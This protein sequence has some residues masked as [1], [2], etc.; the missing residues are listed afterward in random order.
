MCHSQGNVLH[1]LANWQ[2]LFFYCFTWYHDDAL[3]LELVIT[4]P[5]LTYRHCFHIPARRSH[6]VHSD[7]TNVSPEETLLKS[8]EVERVTAASWSHHDPT[9]RTNASLHCWI[10]NGFMAALTLPFLNLYNNRCPANLFTNVGL[11]L[12]SSFA[13]LQWVPF[14]TSQYQNRKS[15]TSLSPYSPISLTPLLPGS[16]LNTQ[17]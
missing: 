4:I 8:F 16:R 7:C 5:V 6:I 15:M 2:T 12:P 13:S 1:M 10:S 9:D 11:L 17:T 14:G 3:L